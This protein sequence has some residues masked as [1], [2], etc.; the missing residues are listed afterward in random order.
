MI[1]GPLY[2]QD[3]YNK[4]CMACHGEN[5]KGNLAA[6]IPPLAGS[7]W[8]NT[9]PE[10]TTSII[11]HGLNGQINVAGKVYDGVMPAQGAMLSDDEMSDLVR[12]ISKN[13]GNNGGEISPDKVAELREIKPDGFGWPA[14]ALLKKYKVVFKQTE[15]VDETPLDHLV[16]KV[17]YG[18]FTSPEELEALK[19]DEITQ[20]K[21]VRGSFSKDEF[22]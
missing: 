12:Y 6:G 1:T 21:V 3:N 16:T 2:G 15:A 19:P 14:E 11:L 22:K 5:G 13:W 7:E 17:Y 9:D 8:V 10:L 4:Y 18:A 20:I